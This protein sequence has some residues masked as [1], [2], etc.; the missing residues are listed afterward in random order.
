MEAALRKKCTQHTEECRSF[1]YHCV[2]NER[3]SGLLEVCAPF[4][5]IL[6]G[7]C[8]DFNIGL[9]SIRKSYTADCTNLNNPCPTSYNSTKSYLYPG[10]YQMITAT[11]MSTAETTARNNTN[12]T[13][14]EDCVGPVG[15]R[16][17]KEVAVLEKSE[18]I[19]ISISIILVVGVGI[20]V[21]LWRLKQNGN[22]R[23]I[24]KK[25]YSE[26]QQENTV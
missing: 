13:R 16:S 26:V 11:T 1:E 5:I 9:Q 15:Q 14:T 6:S 8:T 4:R 10:C 18:I 21:F 3:M 12:S 25:Q 17:G 2:M 20:G 19:A 24:E 22:L 23:N 7:K